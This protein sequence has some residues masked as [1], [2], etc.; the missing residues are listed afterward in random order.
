MPWIKKTLLTVFVVSACCSRCRAWLRRESDPR[1]PGHRGL[2]VRSRGAGHARKCLWRDRRR[3]RS[4]VRDRR[5]RSDRQQRGRSGRHRA[6]VHADAAGR[7]VADDHSEQDRRR[8]T[9]HQSLALHAP[10]LRAGHRPH[11]QHEAGTD[12]RDG[13]GNPRHHPRPTRSR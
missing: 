12:G 11:L 1:R 4:A 7:Q 3:D 8:G 10:A 2:G 6:A 13:G 5:D 9:D